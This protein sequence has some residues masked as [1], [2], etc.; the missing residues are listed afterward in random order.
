MRMSVIT[1]SFNSE[2]TIRRTIESVLNQTSNDFEYLI[3]DGASTDKTLSI[4][5][6][7]KKKFE[8][9]GISYRIHSGSDNGI[10]DAMDKGIAKA[11]GEIIGIVNSDD[12]YEQDAVESVIKM[13]DQKHF[14]ICMFSLNLW[15]GNKKR[16]KSPRI[17]RFK[18]SRDF[19]HPAMFVTRETYKRIGVYSRTLF[20]GDF[21]F[22]LRAL[23][24]D[25][26]ITLSDKVVTN[27]VMG[28]IS[29]QKSFTAMAMRIW[30]R[31]KAYQHN[32]CSGIYYL[33]SVLAETAKML[34]A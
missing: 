16:V 23:K 4:V 34:F 29:S 10:Y 3:I 22:W 28:G 27:Y 6:D 17:R 11:R 21:D 14:D 31:C 19:C 5:R 18:T 1:V 15:K 32:G 20:Y 24:R 13:Y 33:E 8:K 25:V 26:K 2:A 9:R 7:Y 30:E 12:W